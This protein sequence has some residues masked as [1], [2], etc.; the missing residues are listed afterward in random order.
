M[1]AIAAALAALEMG[2]PFA[3]RSLTVFPLGGPDGREPDH[4]T[5]DEALGRGAARVTEVSE[6]GRV[7]ELRFE[8]RG[9]EKVLLVDGEELL[10]AKQNRV[11]NVTILVGGR[12]TVTIPVSCVEQGRWSWKSPEFSAAE[13]VQFSRSRAA[14]AAQ[15]SLNLK[16]SG[17]PRSEQGEVWESIAAKAFSLGVSSPTG[18]M[19][20]IYDQAAGDLEAY[21][22]ELRP[23]PGQA[24]AVFAIAG[25][26]AGM[27]LFDAP[28]TLAKLW[29]KLVASYALD[30]LEA[31]LGRVL[32]LR[33]ASLDGR[34]QAFLAEVGGAR[35]EPFPG[36][37]LGE[38]V[39]LDRAGMAGGG[40]VYEGRVVHLGAFPVPGEDAGP[41]RMAGLSRRRHHWR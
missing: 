16:V 2:P 30:A 20:D 18:A 11:L 29:D 22:R 37:G 31:D 25:E 6:G 7:P 33:P 19:S 8:N 36:V 5:M 35:T 3:F 32:P 21:R 39:R 12:Q 34:A 40:L 24:G 27:D 10:G 13:R 38:Q 26:V 23:R 1:N 9:D 15:V 28:A 14:K 17:D 41:G 4:L